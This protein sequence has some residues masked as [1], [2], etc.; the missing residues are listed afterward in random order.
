MSKSLN[1]AIYLSDDEDTIRSKVKMMYT[2]PNHIHKNDPGKVEGNVVF[3]YLD[4]FDPDTK[5]VAELKQKYKK[6]GLGDVEIKERLANLLTVLFENFRLRRLALEK[7]PESVMKVLEIGTER[8]RE[9]AR[10]T[11]REVRK[12]MRIDY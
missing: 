7:D 10:E 11:M 2:D 9:V 5:T 1:N 12:A 6:G 8:A 4:I 3:T